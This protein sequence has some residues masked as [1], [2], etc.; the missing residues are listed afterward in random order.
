[1]AI[2]PVFPVFLPVQQSFWFSTA[3]DLMLTLEIK[4]GKNV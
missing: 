4:K 1:M 3:F 2:P